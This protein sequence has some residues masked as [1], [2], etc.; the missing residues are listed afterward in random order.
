M[1]GRSTNKSEF[2]KR[3]N[4]ETQESLGV[5]VAAP[6]RILKNYGSAL[7]RKCRRHPGGGGARN[8]AR[9]D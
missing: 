4:G 3:K 6:R 2:W 1:A 7:A 5:T 8:F 9:R